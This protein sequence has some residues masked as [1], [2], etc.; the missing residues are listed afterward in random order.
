MRG[1]AGDP[2]RTG[3]VAGVQ[4]TGNGTKDHHSGQADD[5]WGQSQTVVNVQ[6]GTRRGAASDGRDGETGGIGRGAAARDT[7]ANALL[8][9]STGLHKAKE[10][11]KDA[12][13]VRRL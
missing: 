8:G 7:G 13:Q 3:Q 6:P 12:G 5:W 4:N 9:A 10:G 2:E 11:N 1:I